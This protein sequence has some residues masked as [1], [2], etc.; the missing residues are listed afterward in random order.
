MTSDTF[1]IPTKCTISIVY[2]HLMRVYYVRIFD[3]EIR[4]K[5]MCTIDTVRLCCIRKVCEEVVVF[6]EELG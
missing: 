2:V 5:C 1:L 3:A 6:Q 4:I